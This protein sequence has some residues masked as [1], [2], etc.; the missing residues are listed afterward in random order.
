MFSD[1][2]QVFVFL[3]FAIG[4][5]AI[6]LISAKIVSPKRPTKGKYKTYEC[7]EDT[8]GDTWVKFNIRFYITALI[9]IIFDVEIVFLFPW[10]VV[11]KEM[12]MIAFIEMAMFLLILIVGLVYVWAKGDLQWDKPQPVIPKLEREIF[13][14]GN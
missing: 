14:A 7:G 1:Y 8:V 6:A 11:F 9:F 13:K 10:A 2:G 3:I 12:G 4:F 5:V